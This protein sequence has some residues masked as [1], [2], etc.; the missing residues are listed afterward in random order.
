PELPARVE[1]LEH[2]ASVIREAAHDGEIE[3]HKLADAKRLAAFEV[4]RQVGCALGDFGRARECFANRVRSS[5][6]LKTE[7]RLDGGRVQ[8]R[9]REFLARDLGGLAI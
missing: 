9:G 6:A 3:V 1:Q 2:D 5:Q 4:P 8:T 7:D